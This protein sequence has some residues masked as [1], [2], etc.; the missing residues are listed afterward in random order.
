[1]L[2]HWSDKEVFVLA[3]VSAMTKVVM[4]IKFAGSVLACDVFLPAV[5]DVIA[6]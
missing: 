5:I 2:P 6:K 1:M 3:L 4:R